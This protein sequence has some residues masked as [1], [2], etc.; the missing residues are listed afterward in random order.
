M[1]SQRLSAG[2]AY[3]K[4]EIRRRRRLALHSYPLGSHE[5]TAH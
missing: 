3:A 2:I 1:A 5:T 4:M